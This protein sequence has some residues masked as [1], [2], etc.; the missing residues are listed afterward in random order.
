MSAHHQQI[1]ELVDRVRSRWRRLTLFRAAVRAAIAA[2]LVLAVGLFLTYWTTRTPVALAPLGLVALT[3]VAG[4]IVWGFW[5]VRRTPSEAQVARFLEERDPSLDDRL[6]SAVDLL[7]GGRES[8]AP[9]L[10]AP[11]V[12]DAARRASVVDPS[13]VVSRDILRRAGVQ[14]VAAAVLLAAVAFFG[15]HTARQ[16]FDALSLTLFPSRVALE[17]TPGNARVRPG[18]PLTIQARLV[19]NS[20]PVVARVLRTDG[21]GAAASPD[22]QGW[23]ASEMTAERPG[24]FTL[25][26]E[27]IGSS[28]TYRVMAGNLT[29]PPFE[30][31]VVRP[32]RGTRIDVDYSYPP[33]LGLPARTE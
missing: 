19:G 8:E 24:A 22:A 33:A 5:P 13:S 11:M 14:A 31:T 23:R 2:S 16:S 15:R 20:A 1:R 7:V 25:A 27:S 29:S 32:P 28:F 6:A 3:L 10:A 21:I 9:G 4:A 30:V 12:A 17:I 26:I 18:E